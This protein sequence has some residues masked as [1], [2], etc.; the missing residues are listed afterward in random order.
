MIVALTSVGRVRF[1]G[2]SI[3]KFTIAKTWMNSCV[4]RPRIKGYRHSTE[5]RMLCPIK[6]ARRARKE[7][8]DLARE[9]GT[10]FDHVSKTGVGAAAASSSQCGPE[11]WL[12]D[13]GS[14]FDLIGRH[15]VPDWCARLATPTEG[16]VELSMPTAE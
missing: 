3:S 11:R 1:G 8:V 16:T 9:L 12:V 5:V 10:S 14:A 2:V 13:T 4:S 6:E 7:A 15:D